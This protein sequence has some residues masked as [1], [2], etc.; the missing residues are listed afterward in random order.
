MWA[1]YAGI[2]FLHFAALLFVLC[3]VILIVVSVLTPPPA[4]ER[5]ADL[6]VQTTK[7]LAD[8]ADSPKE[9]RVATIFS[10]VLAAT[11]GTLWIV[12]R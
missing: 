6:T 2:N 8:T 5:V 7:P 12:F 1:W 9:R 11:I 4:A 10:I 3:S